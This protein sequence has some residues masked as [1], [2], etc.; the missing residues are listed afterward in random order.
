MNYIL[1]NNVIFNQKKIT[2]C[3]E[4]SDDL[5]KKFLNPDNSG[6]YTK[7]DYDGVI[8]E[9]CNFMK[10]KQAVLIVSTFYYRLPCFVNILEMEFAEKKQGFKNVTIVPLFKFFCN[11]SHVNNGAYTFHEIYDR[12]LI[13]TTYSAGNNAVRTVKQTVKKQNINVR[14][15]NII[16]WKG[17]C[18]LNKYCMDDQLNSNDLKLTN[19]ADISALKIDDR[20]YTIDSFYREIKQVIDNAADLHSAVFS[21]ILFPYKIAEYLDNSK[22][23]DIN[24]TQSSTIN[25][26]NESAT[27]CVKTIPQFEKFPLW[28]LVQQNDNCTP[29]IE[30]IRKK[31]SEEISTSLRLP[32]SWFENE[33]F[34][35]GNSIK[36]IKFLLDAEPDIF[37]NL[38][39]GIF[40]IGNQF[41][42]NIINFEK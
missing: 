24:K 33:I 12:F 8:N 19:F 36:V 42:F 29:S 31:G 10:D 39:A 41:I 15:K 25:L 11:T 23:V 27:Y 13:S 22:I 35:V 6:Y 9:I 32:V 1:L 3:K 14:H 21:Y 38:H 5:T 2:D 26:Q 7:K 17:L 40:T 20:N 34:H 30:L 37:N 28:M 16:T 18:L 4:L